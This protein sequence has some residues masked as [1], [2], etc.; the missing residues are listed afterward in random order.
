M[1]DICN[2][3][4]ASFCKKSIVKHTQSPR[5]PERR[6]EED[7]IGRGAGSCLDWVFLYVAPF[8]APFS[9]LCPRLESLCKGKERGCLPP[10]SG[11]GLSVLHPHRAPW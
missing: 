9:G 5:T 3:A 11:I 1:S 6:E 7:A 2:V 8:S 10:V 4:V